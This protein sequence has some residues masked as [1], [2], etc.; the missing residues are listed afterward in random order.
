MLGASFSAYDP[1]RTWLERPDFVATATAVSEFSA[2]LF[3]MLSCGVVLVLGCLKVMTECNPG[4]MRGLLV[5]ARFVVLGGFAMILGSLIIV[6]RCLFVMLVNF[7]F[8][9]SFLPGPFTWMRRVVG[10]VEQRAGEHKRKAPLCAG[11]MPF[12]AGD[13]TF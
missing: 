12:V 13:V 7:V 3:C 6:L 8:F 5:I 11:A 2:V 4:M 1:K 10:I 9:H